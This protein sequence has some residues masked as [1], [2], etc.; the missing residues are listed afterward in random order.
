MPLVS[1]WNRSARRGIAAAEAGSHRR[2]GRAFASLLYLGL[3][4]WACA[5]TDDNVTTDAA[6]RNCEA[7]LIVGF[8]ET[9]GEPSAELLSQAAQAQVEIRTSIGPSLY[10]V[11]LR[12]DGSADVCMAAVDRLR[13]VAGVRSVDFDTRR[14]A[15][16][17]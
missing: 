1:V 6:G 2:W 11:D 3:G 14:Q 9:A 4:A 16:T 13:L 8:D 7:R 12:A 17:P 15:H 10:A 5:H